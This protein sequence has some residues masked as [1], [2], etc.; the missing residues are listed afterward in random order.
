MCKW[1]RVEV[2]VCG[3]RCRCNSR[4]R[5]QR[6]RVVRR[7]C[8]G[9]RQITGAVDMEGGSRW[10]VFNRY[11]NAERRIVQGRAPAGQARQSFTLVPPRGLRGAGQ[12][13]RSQG[14]RC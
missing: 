6:A 9:A 14:E 4:C 8:S 11:N 13:W 1:C 7:G 10:W 3:C 12:G 5:P 2:Q